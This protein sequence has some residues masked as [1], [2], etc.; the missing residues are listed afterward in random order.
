[1]DV[2]R[3]HEAERSLSVAL[4]EQQGL[5]ERL[6]AAQEAETAA[7]KEAYEATRCATHEHRPH[8][9]AGSLT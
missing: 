1:M 2:C 4:D 9:H 7:R 8:P 3:C 6:T 5:T